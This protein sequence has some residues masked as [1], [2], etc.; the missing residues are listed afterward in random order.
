MKK[1]FVLCLTVIVAVSCIAVTACNL[2]NNTSSTAVT[3]HELIRENFAVEKEAEDDAKGREHIDIPADA[4][5]IELDNEEWVVLRS[6]EEFVKIWAV[7]QDVVARGEDL[8][9]NYIVANDI[10]VKGFRISYKESFA[11]KFNGNNYKFYGTEA[12]GGIN[13][14]LFQKLENAQVENIIFSSSDGYFVGEEFVP[15]VNTLIARMAENSTI[16]NCINY[17]QPK[18]YSTAPEEYLNEPPYSG[19]LVYY[20]KNCLI[21][22][23]KNYGDFCNSNSGI[24]YMA[25]DCTINYCKNYGNLA[26]DCDVLG[27]V[28]G[29][30][31]GDNIIK[32]CENYGD[33]IGK[34]RL[35]GIVGSVSRGV[36]GT[37]PD[38]EGLNDEYFTKNQL[39]KDCK[40]FGNIYL[41]KEA[42]GNRIETTG[43]EGY[44]I[45]YAKIIYEF[46]GI[47]GSISKVENCIN[48]G[49]FYGFEN[50]GDGIKVDYL[51]GVVGATKQV[52][53][54]EN[55]G[56]MNVQKGRALNVGE[57]YGF[58][59]N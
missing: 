11:G 37:F 28:V 1:L 8:K 57:I 45:G 39:I 19:G 14:C 30:V 49:N 24:L 48:E 50:M 51:G 25:E 17:F 4:E 33:I 35:G 26:N 7:P 59:D 31:I 41:L 23:C 44:N 5:T 21:E 38:S 20:A 43:N 53:G 2:E 40:N 10:D 54:C 27:G 6:I 47:A 22:K 9:K 52:V 18:N 56:K 29:K 58:L 32:N 36:N 3:K 12:N 42:G 15:A 13:N 34:N 46:G 16:K 55:K